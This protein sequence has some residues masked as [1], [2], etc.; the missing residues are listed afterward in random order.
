MP[1][2]IRM[3]I[4]YHWMMEYLIQLR[5]VDELHV[6]SLSRWFRWVDYIG[7][8]VAQP[9]IDESDVVGAVDYELFKTE[10]RDWTDVVHL[11]KEFSVRLAKTI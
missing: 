3:S 6:D 9:V 11:D 4:T 10:T 7:N 2:D 8:Q 1:P 5:H